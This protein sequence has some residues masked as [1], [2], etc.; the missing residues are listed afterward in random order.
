LRLS[1]DFVE[2]RF[3]LGNA[4]AT[5]GRLDEAAAEYRA[6]LK[7]DPALIATWCNLGDALAQSGRID[8]AAASSE[9][10][11]HRAPDSAEAREGLA[12]LRA[13]PPTGK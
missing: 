8:E 7:L 2:A 3:N 11:L 13:A 9:E 10:A 6:A 4:L 12:R 1:P 5:L